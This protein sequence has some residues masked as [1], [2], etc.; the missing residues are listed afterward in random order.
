M[1]LAREGSAGARES[2]AALALVAVALGA[3]LLHAHYLFR[4]P[5]DDA[6]ISVSYARTFAEGQGFR[7][8]PESAIAEGFSNP[9]WTLLLALIEWLGGDS[10]TWLRPLGLWFAAA[11]LVLIAL[12]GPIAERRALQLEDALAPLLAAAHPSFVHWVQGGLEM[13]L[14]VFAIGAVG[15]FALGE[16]DRWRANLLGASAALL[17]L[18]RPE[19]PIYAV[20]A[21]LGWLGMLIVARRLPGKLELRAL[22][23]AALP[24]LAYV[25]V[26]RW[27]FGF[28]L[29]NTYYAKHSWDFGA[30]LYLTG[31]YET[32]KPLWHAVFYATPLAL[33]GHARTRVRALV[34][35]A[36]LAALTYFAWYARGDWMR[37]WRFLAVV[38]PFQG[39]V[40]GAAV[41]ALRDRVPLPLSALATLALL[42]ELVPSELARSEW[43]KAQG[44]DVP[45]A[46]GRGVPYQPAAQAAL[47]HGIVHA[48]AIASD[49]GIA[50]IGL[51]NFELWDFAG[52]TDPATSRQ[53]DHLG[54][55]H[56]PQFDDFVEHEGPPSM[57][58]TWGPGAFFRHR[59]AARHYVEFAPN[60][61]IFRGLG[62]DTD[63]R[64]PGGKPAV[65]AETPA[66]LLASIARE[67]ESD[68]V[69]ALARWRC[70]YTYKHDAELPPIAERTRL[71]QEI[72]ARAQGKPAERRLRMYSLCATVS[73]QDGSVSVPCRRKAEA[74]RT[75]LFG[76]KL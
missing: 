5:V 60:Y 51:R 73:L 76:E 32:Y 47:D 42:W 10:L 6:G 70:A 7:L 14:Q 55:L 75:K 37:E 35:I 25:L 15:V 52:L 50:G 53:F 48:S 19:A 62:P 49:M 72:A 46:L 4:L 61:F 33:L 67:A 20:A 13:S 16:H 69:R 31:F 59:P 2:G 74:L 56:F 29:P 22:T 41:S 40:L 36:S 43:V 68:P 3:F 28:W 45:V 23:V 12:W 27:Y 34:A 18:T 63:P 26:R 71:A 11:G 8:T 9:S 66:Q 21:G 44:A 54:G 58:F 30:E 38:A 57:A 1:T 17:I 39:A 64:C 24:V 65:L